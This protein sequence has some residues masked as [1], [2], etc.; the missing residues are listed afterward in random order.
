MVKVT[1][2]VKHK[3]IKKRT[4]TFFRMHS[5]RFMRVPVRASRVSFA[6]VFFVHPV[7]VLSVRCWC[8][9]VRLLGL[10]GPSRL[11]GVY[12]LLYC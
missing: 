10:L 7:S 4:A 11:F 9:F 3:Q 1:P 8:M 5:N 12:P 6:A 2:L